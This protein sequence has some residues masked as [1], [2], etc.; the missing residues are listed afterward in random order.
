MIMMTKEWF[1]L[2]NQLKNHVVESTKWKIRN[3]SKYCSMYAS[4]E[5]LPWLSAY[6]SL[7]SIVTNWC[8][9]IKWRHINLLLYKMFSLFLA[10][11]SIIY[12]ALLRSPDITLSSNAHSP[13]RMKYII[14]QEISSEQNVSEN[15]AAYKLIFTAFHPQFIGSELR[16]GVAFPRD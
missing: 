7:F 13:I 2:Q 16:L 12:P 8:F 11:R 10:F 1:T 6:F 15:L 5:Q 9:H 3:I 14:N 4:L